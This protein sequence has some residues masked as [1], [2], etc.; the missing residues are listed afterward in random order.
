MLKNILV[1]VIKAIN[2]EV[3]TR[4]DFLAKHGKIVYSAVLGV[5]TFLSFIIYQLISDREIIRST[6]TD[7]EYD[8]TLK[9][10]SKIAQT[11]QNAPK[12]ITILIDE[13]YLRDNNLSNS[14]GGLRFNFTPRSMLA[15][16]LNELN[17]AIDGAKPKIVLLDYL[18]PHPSDINAT[19][20]TADDKYLIDT[21]N[22]LEFPV[23]LPTYSDKIF[24][25]DEKLS[26][27]ITFGSTL[28][29]LASD[30]VARSYSPYFCRDNKVFFHIASLLG[31]S[32]ANKENELCNTEIK[33]SYI[34]LLKTRILYKGLL[35]TGNTRYSK[36]SNV[37][38]YSATELASMD[39]DFENAIVLIGSDH[40]GSNDIYKTSV[41]TRSGVLILADAINTAYITNGEGLKTLPTF[42]LA[43]AYGLILF[44]VTFLVLR[45]CERIGISKIPAKENLILLANILVFFIPSFIMVFYGY[46]V[47]WIV[48]L[49]L[50]K[51]IDYIFIAI[52]KLKFIKIKRR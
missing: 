15:N 25:E 6:F 1:Y 18:L 36:Y 49:I 9:L 7:F 10:Y 52:E 22:T 38:I 33:H 28:I 44:V 47:S 12:I 43:P 46:Y 17:I 24:I 39:E 50:F 29:S 4:A 27:N 48:P 5:F 34:D 2:A 20:P 11:P 37:L 26:P 32:Y 3:N 19:A 8:T 30:N 35:G 14:D 40:S 23:F 42:V 13:N 41:D 51:V 45:L 21:L 16:V 31:N